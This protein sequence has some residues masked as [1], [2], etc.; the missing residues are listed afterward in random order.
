MKRH[1][2]EWEQIFANQICDKGLIFRIYK[3][4]WNSKVKRQIKKKT[5]KPHIEKSLP[6]C[7]NG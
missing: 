6:T 7:N 4:S 5:E 2:A 1:P 3:N